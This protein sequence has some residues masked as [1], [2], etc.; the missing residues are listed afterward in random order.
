MAS[1]EQQSTNIAYA[2]R[3]YR[4]GGGIAGGVLVIALILWLGSDALFSGTG[5]TPWLALAG[6]LLVIPL[7]AAFTVRP[8]VFAGP[9]RL[10]IRNPFRL[11]TVPWGAVESLQARFSTEVRTKG[12]PKYQLWAVP[13]S[14]RQRKR[15]DRRARGG[16][17]GMTLSMNRARAEALATAHDE[18]QPAQADQA[19][20]EM[21]D[22]AQ[23][24]ADRPEAQGAPTV[25]WAY[26]VLGPALAGAIL[27]AVLLLA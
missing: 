7:L 12:G 8:A 19:I 4:S 3:A 10:R 17:R 2:D 16:P 14:L 11:I 13:V 5:R 20:A 21:R 6:M 9:D 25:R 1:P 24:A 18:P 15:A 22:L 26:E 23:R 27:L